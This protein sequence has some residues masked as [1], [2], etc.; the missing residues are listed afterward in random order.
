MTRLRARAMIGLAALGVSACA[1]VQVRLPAGPWTA[2]PTAVEAF[3][4]ATAACRGARTLTAEIGVSGR[5]GE[6]RVRGRLLAAVERPGRVR[7]EAIAPFGA[8][9]FILAG[10]DGRATLLLPRER[11]YVAEADTSELLEAIT[12]LRRSVDDLLALIA[13]CAVANAGPAPGS[14]NRAGW[15]A[16][17]VDADVTAFL[18]RDGG[19]W[20]L[21]AASH[22]GGAP[23]LPP[24]LIEYGDFVSGF[25]ATIRLREGAPDSPAGT[26]VDLT[27][28]IAQREVNVAVDPAAFSVVTR[29]A[30]T[31]TLDELRQLGPLA[32]RE[33][34]TRTD[35]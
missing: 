23:A 25:P 10:R 11:R 5:A 12:G 35:R 31:M 32:D 21:R 15:L 17:G 30:A 13:G 1:P 27:L 19:G 33:P 4:E 20:R 7:I 2:D 14:R 16:V 26:S 9:I 18:R 22:A 24:W 3:T 29:G 6:T 34:G 8:P 28:R